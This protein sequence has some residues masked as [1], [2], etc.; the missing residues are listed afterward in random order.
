MPRPLT[1][2]SAL[3]RAKRLLGPT[4]AV[5]HRPGTPAPYRVGSQQPG[6]LFSVKGIGA[7]WA[8]AIKRAERVTAKN[9]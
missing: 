5:C 7:T 8:E 4:A 9:G 6:G 1:E 2:R 3:T